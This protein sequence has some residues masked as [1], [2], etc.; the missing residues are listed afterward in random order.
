MLVRPAQ[1]AD[2]DQVWPLARDLATSFRPDRAAFDALFTSLLADPDALVLAAP[3]QDRD[4][5]VD[6][7]GGAAVEGGPPVAAPVQARVVGEPDGPEPGAGGAGDVDAGGG[8]E[9][10]SVLADPQGDRQ[11]P[12]LR[13]PAG[14]YGRS[15][16]TVRR[17][18]EVLRERGLIVTIHGR[19]TF[20]AEHGE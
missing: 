16:Q 10:F 5:D 3:A 20:V 7:G 4:D 14:Y 12:V 8:L 6:K 19:G 2:R 13:R 17:A 9:R 18:M 1:A 15:Y 11:A